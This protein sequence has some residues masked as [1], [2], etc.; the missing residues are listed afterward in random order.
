MEWSATRETFIVIESYPDYCGKTLTMG[1]ARWLMKLW[2]HNRR[3]LTPVIVR[4]EDKSEC[5]SVCGL[6]HRFRTVF[7]HI[8]LNGL[9]LFQASH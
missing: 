5:V 4:G 6:M 2:I 3:R 9:A 1:A 8:R 7:F